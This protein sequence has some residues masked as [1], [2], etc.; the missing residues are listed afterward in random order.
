[1]IVKVVSSAAIVNLVVAEKSGGKYGLSALVE[2]G[3]YD[4]LV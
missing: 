3:D 2:D 1:M 4:L